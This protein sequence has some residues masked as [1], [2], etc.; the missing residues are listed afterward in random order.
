MLVVSE[1]Q[2]QCLRVPSLVGLERPR[3]KFEENLL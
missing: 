3:G 1:G 2:F